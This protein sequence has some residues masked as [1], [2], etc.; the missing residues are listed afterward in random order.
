[1]SELD[2]ESEP[3]PGWRDYLVV[4][5]VLAITVGLAV[6]VM[7]SLGVLPWHRSTNSRT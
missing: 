1:M 2:F 4:I 6:G 3:V 7:Y 5:I